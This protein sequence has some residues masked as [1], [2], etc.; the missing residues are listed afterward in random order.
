[1]YFFRGRLHRIAEQL[2]DLIEQLSDEN[3]EEVWKVLQPL[4]YD[5]YML[6]AIQESMQAISPGDT[7][8][9]EEALRFLQLP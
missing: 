4:Y 3:L 6:V 2:P 5:L 8:T 7:L 1:M 9:R